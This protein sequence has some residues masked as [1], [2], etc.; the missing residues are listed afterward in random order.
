MLGKNC[1][2]NTEEN[3][4]T[5]ILKKQTEKKRDHGNNNNNNNNNNKTKTKTESVFLKAEHSK[6]QKR[7]RI[8]ADHN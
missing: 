4:R 6:Q 3:S 1:S 7:E 2:V 5:Y 8:N